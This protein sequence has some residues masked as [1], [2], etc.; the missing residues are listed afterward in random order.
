MIYMFQLNFI[1]QYYKFTF[2]R[3]LFIPLATQIDQIFLFI[4][5]AIL[6]TNEI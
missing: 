6:V 3:E 1:N 2:F 5:I 4:C